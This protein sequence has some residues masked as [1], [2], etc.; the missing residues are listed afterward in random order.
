MNLPI[1]PGMKWKDLPTHLSKDEYQAMEILVDTFAEEACELVEGLPEGDVV[2]RIVLLP[3]TP[4]RTVEHVKASLIK[5]WDLGL[6]RFY[7]NQEENRI[8][9]EI[10][11][12]TGTWKKVFKRRLTDD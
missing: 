3:G 10:W 7:S 5:L 11:L 8:G 4:S 2:R 9:L 6:I 1:P 12:P